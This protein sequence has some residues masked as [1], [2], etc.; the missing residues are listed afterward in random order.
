MQ[1]QALGQLL[2]IIKIELAKQDI[3][4]SYRCQLMLAQQALEG[5]KR[6]W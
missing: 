3:N 1:Y 4:V 5:L 6:F 2:S